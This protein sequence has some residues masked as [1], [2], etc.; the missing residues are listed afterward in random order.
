MMGVAYS[1]RV[2]VRIGEQL[3]EHHLKSYSITTYTNTTH[4]KYNTIYHGTYLSPKN[5]PR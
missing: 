3:C 5:I 4:I 1:H 2:H